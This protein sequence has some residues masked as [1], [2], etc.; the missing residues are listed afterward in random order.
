MPI[1]SCVDD[2]R[3]IL[4][5]VFILVGKLDCYDLEFVRISEREVIAFP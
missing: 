2:K 4:A 3:E 5:A 1:L